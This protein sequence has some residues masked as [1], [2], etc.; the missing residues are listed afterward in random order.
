MLLKIHNLTNRWL[1]GI[2]STIY[3]S[4]THVSLEQCHVENAKL[5][6]NRELML[7]LLPQN[8]ICAEI[9]V[10]MG[11]FTEKILQSANPKKLHLID[12]WGTER[13]GTSKKD[14]VSN[15][16]AAEI[17]N[18]TIEMNLGYSTEVL[19]QFPDHYF[20]WLYI[21]TDHSYP[22]TLAELYLSAKKVKQGGLITGHDFTVGYWINGV[23]YGVI[24]AVYE[25]CVKEGWEIV[26]LTCEANDHRSFALRKIEK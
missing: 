21:D 6:A 5:L 13:Y 26:Y 16:F 11:N 10:D 7:T 17:K 9:G 15:K 2:K 22:T 1:R 8:A 18:G 25:F 24:E 3:N 12:F 20:D 14:L 4:M 23:K 19:P